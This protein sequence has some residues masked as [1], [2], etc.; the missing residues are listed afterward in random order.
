MIINYRTDWK[1][2]DENRSAAYGDNIGVILWYY[3]C[4]ILSPVPDVNSTSHSLFCEHNFRQKGKSA[5]QKVP[6]GI[7]LCNR[8]CKG[9]YHRLIIV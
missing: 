3:I 8:R 1:I 2:D 4:I 7:F 6:T 9:F 5:A